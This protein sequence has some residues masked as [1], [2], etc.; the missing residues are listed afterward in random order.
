[1]PVTRSALALTGITKRSAL[2]SVSPVMV[3]FSKVVASKASRRA[4]A[5]YAIVGPENAPLSKA[6]PRTSVPLTFD[7]IMLGRNRPISSLRSLKTPSPKL[8][9]PSAS[10]STAAERTVPLSCAT[11]SAKVAAMSTVAMGDSA[12]MSKLSAIIL[13]GAAVPLTANV[14]SRAVSAIS[15]MFSDAICAVSLPSHL[16]QSPRPLKLAFIGT[17][18]PIRPA[19]KPFAGASSLRSTSKRLSSGTA[20]SFK[21]MRS[22]P[23]LP[24]LASIIARRSAMR[25]LPDKEAMCAAPVTALAKTMRSTCIRSMLMSKSGKSGL[26]RSGTALNM[27][28]RD[29]FNSFAVSAWIAMPRRRYE[30]GFQSSRILGARAKSPFGSRKRTSDKIASL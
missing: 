10:I 4:L 26:P 12:R 14:P 23:S 18:R 30:S 22:P 20:S 1:M 29:T 5:E 25:S 16:R 9:I 2:P 24:A 19:T 28:I 21:R 17:S 6:L 13:A 8:T 3:T 27:G 11:R 7:P 15:A